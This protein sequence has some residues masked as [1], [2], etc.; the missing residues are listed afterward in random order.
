MISLA[1]PLKQE[2]LSQLTKAFFLVFHSRGIYSSWTGSAHEFISAGLRFPFPP[3]PRRGISCRE[4]AE[5]PRGAQARFVLRLLRGPP[6]L[7]VH[8][9]CSQHPLKSPC[10]RTN[11]HWHMGTRGR[12]RFWLR[13]TKKRW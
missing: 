11:P 12:E 2:A 4:R 1:F 10:V 3:A 7:P 5:T 9:N 6:G 13:M 8:G